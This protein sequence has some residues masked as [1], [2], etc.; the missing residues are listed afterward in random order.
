MP[1]H[2][3]QSVT[4][5]KVKSHTCCIFVRALPKSCT[6]KFHLNVDDLVYDNVYSK[7]G[8][9]NSIRSQDIKQ[10]L[11]SYVNQGPFLCCKFAKNDNLLSQS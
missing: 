6:D 8:L 10:K 3:D 1:I 11:I 5:D 7:I 2:A 4:D 9:N